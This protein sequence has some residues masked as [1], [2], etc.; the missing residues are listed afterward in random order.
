MEYQSYLEDIY[1]FQITPLKNTV[2]TKIKNLYMDDY[3]TKF[4]AKF[5]AYLMK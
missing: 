1:N 4:T 5:Y 3:Y 2:P